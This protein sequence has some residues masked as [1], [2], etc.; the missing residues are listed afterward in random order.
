MARIL[1]I[2][3]ES[4]I[5]FTIA[6]S[7]RGNGHEIV[8]CESLPEADEA[9]AQSRFDAIL[10]DVNLGC[11][12]GIDLVARLR[13]E[14]F[15]GVIIVMTGY[16]S[17]ESAV[18]AMRVGADDYLE[19]PVRLDELGILV[20]RLLTARADRRKLRLYK[21]LEGV[22]GAVSGVIGQSPGWLQ[23]LSLAER[24]AQSPLPSTH[25]PRAGASLPTILLLGETG[26]GKGVLARHIHDASLKASGSADAP[27]V[28]VNCS[29]LPAA[30][31]ESELFG[32]ER[33]AFTDARASREGLF[34][35]ADGGTIFLDEIGDMP[36]ELQAKL[37]SVLERGMI[38]RI[39]GSR[40]TPVRVRVVA[41]TNQDLEQRAS[42]GFFRKDLLYRLNALTIRIPPLRERGEDGVL[43]GC[44]S[45]DRM[46]REYGR[47]PAKLS[48]DAMDAIRAYGWPGN[49][50]ELLNTMQ[51][52]AMLCDQ[53]EITA[54]DLGLDLA[55]AHAS[56]EDGD[57]VALNS[58]RTSTGGLHFDFDAGSCT[59]T[60][61]ERELMKQS[62]A[63]TR[64]NVSRA[65]KLIGMQRSSFRYRIERYGL[66]SFVREASQ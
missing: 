6:R 36:L 12:N 14:G 17:V 33:G 25:D 52:V 62:L 61:V 59:F 45:L 49:V 37:L 15:D 55:P 38:R 39:G 44:A 18:R 53:H 3:D 21:R 10:T 56:S 22:G 13:E 47:P 65:A 9:M 58:D 29:A 34:E 27:Y 64:G 26:V 54:I 1:I 66:E 41:A 32:H 46:L 31:I 8:E 63:K 19:K 11:G 28:H 30:L 5:R 2:E 48:A 51:R 43:I 42:A 7:L 24:M 23:T 57:R 40:E 20:N 16:G 60:E 4:N 35:M 50:R